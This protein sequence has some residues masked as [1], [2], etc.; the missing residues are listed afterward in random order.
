MSQALQCFSDHLLSCHRLIEYP[1]IKAAKWLKFSCTSNL[2]IMD[3]WRFF[4]FLKPKKR[5]SCWGSK[6]FHVAF[7]TIKRNLRVRETNYKELV[8]RLIS[9]RI[10]QTRGC[11][12]FMS[13][14][15]NKKAAIIKCTIYIGC[16]HTASTWS[17]KSCQ[18]QSKRKL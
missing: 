4:F 11:K 3:K 2:I 1:K 12:S 7:V 13:A 14:G 9:K 17:G 6:E 18:R 15:K 8:T 5:C 10:Q 16:I